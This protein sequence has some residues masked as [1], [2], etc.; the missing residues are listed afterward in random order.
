VAGKIIFE[1]TRH[2]HAIFGIA[3]T[4]EALDFGNQICYTLEEC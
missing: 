2:C 3:A 4:R 1:L